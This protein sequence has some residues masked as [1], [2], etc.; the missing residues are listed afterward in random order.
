MRLLAILLALAFALVPGCRNE[1]TPLPSYEELRSKVA[2]YLA[3]LPGT[4]A[5]YFKDL[6]SGESFGINA[7]LPMHP[8]SSIK[9]PVVLYLYEEVAA[10]RRSWEERVFYSAARD[11]QE[12]AGV[13]RYWARDGDAYSLRTLATVSIVTSDNIA[14]NMLVRHL[15][16]EQ[17]MSFLR[18]LAPHTTRPYGS[19]LTTARDLGNCVEEAVRFARAHPELGGRL[20]DDLAH[21]I[22]HYGLPGRLPPEVLVAHKEGSIS[23]V[24]TD[25]GV[26]LSR[27]PYVLSLLA[28]DLP[29]E[30]EGFRHFSAVSRLV[31]EYQQKLPPP[32]APVL[33][34]PAPR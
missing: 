22:F 13:L 2:A 3:P 31:Y 32:P 8:A 33:P 23:G 1:E 5:V 12:G 24:A 9:L 14:H 25:V 4:Y 26:V 16:Q 30:E 6:A 29:D 18:R 21:T 10:G 15:G 19:A 27:R 20:L 11:Y 7:D 17:V 28:R 34:S